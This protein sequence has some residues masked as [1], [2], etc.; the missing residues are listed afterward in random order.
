MRKP[1]LLFIILAINFYFIPDLIQ[2]APQATTY[3]ISSS[4]GDD[5]NDGINAPFQTVAKVNS[6]SLSPGDKVLFKCG[7][8]W[9]GEQLVIRQSGNSSNPI[10]FGSY[11]ENCSDKPILS[12]SLP[13][14]GWSVHSGNIYVADLD[15]GGNNGRFPHGINQLFRNG[16]RRMMGRWPNLGTANGG[17]SVVDGQPS[18]NQITDNQLPGGDWTGGIIHIKTMRWLLVNRIITGSSGSTLSLNDSLSCWGGTC[19]GWG[20][21][22]NNHLS[23]LD[24][25]GEW[26][27]DAASNRIYLYSTVGSPAN[28]EGSAILDT[29]ANTTHGGVMLSSTPPSS[30]VVVDNLAVKNWFNHGISALGSMRGDV[31]H[32]ITVQNTLV[33]DVDV[34]IAEDMD[35]GLLGHDFFGNYDIRIGKDVVEFSQR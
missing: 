25:D 1:V 22:I 33:K 32:H 35:I 4:T 13:I 3:L 24:Q 17:Y 23:T 21:F 16:E 28:M 11:P 2:A 8:V 29:T 6:L 20:Y 34:A 27:Y 15:D 7:D 30:Y 19:Q 5:D 14:S 10:T 9:Q 18:S 12:G 26:Y 31:Y